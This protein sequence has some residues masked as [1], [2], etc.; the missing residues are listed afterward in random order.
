[1]RFN[2]KL[3]KSRMNENLNQV[4]N[5]LDR[6]AKANS[7]V[8]ALN[9][10]D[11]KSEWVDKLNRDEI[12]SLITNSETQK[13]LIESICEKVNKRELKKV[14]KKPTQKKS[15]KE[16]KIEKKSKKSLKEAN[17]VE[18]EQE[19]EQ[20]DS[21]TDNL[22]KACIDFLN[23][24][25]YLTK[26]SDNYFEYEVTPD[27]RDYLNMRD[28]DYIL[29]NN[30]IN[31]KDDFINY[32][33]EAYDFCIDYYSEFEDELFK[34]LDQNDIVYDR[35]DVNDILQEH[36]AIYP[37][38]DFYFRQEF[39][40]HIFVDT[41]DANYDFSLNPT[42]M[43]MT[44]DLED[45]DMNKASLVWLVQQQGYTKED[46]KNLLENGNSESKFLKS[47]Y[48]E[49][50]NNVGNNTTIA[51]LCKTTLGE[52]L[53]W[54]ANPTDITINK[55]TSIGLYDIFSGS[56][57]ILD[58]QL[59]KPLV[60]PAQ[61]IGEFWFDVKPKN[62]GGYSV[63]DVYGL[64]DEAYAADITLGNVSVQENL[65]EAHYNDETGEVEPD[66]FYGIPDVEFIWHGEWSDP[67]IAYQGKLYNY[68]DLE[69]SLY[70]LFEEDIENGDVV[71]D[72]SGYEPGPWNDA[73][74][75]AKDDKFA[76][77]VKDN[78]SL[79]YDEI[80][81]LEPTDTYEENLKESKSL[82]ESDYYNYLDKDYADFLE[83]DVNVYD[84]KALVEQETNGEYTTHYSHEYAIIVCTNGKGCVVDYEAVGQDFDSVDSEIEFGI[85]ENKDNEYTDENG[86]KHKTIS[87]IATH[88]ITTTPKEV[89][90]KAPKKTMKVRE[91]F[92]KYKYNDRC[93]DNFQELAEYVE[94]N[95]GVQESC[96]SKKKSK[97][98]KEGYIGQTLQDFLDDCIDYYMIDKIYIYGDTDIVYEGS[99][100]E[101]PDDMLN[102]E[103]LECEMYSNNRDIVVINVDSSEEYGVTTYYSTVED[104]VGDCNNDTVVVWDI[105]TDKEVFR[106]YR[107]EIPDDV[108]DM[109]FCSY[110][111]PSE[112]S[113]N[114]NDYEPEDNDFDDKDDDFDE[115]LKQFKTKKYNFRES[116]RL[117]K[118]KL[119]TEKKKSIK[120]ALDNEAYNKLANSNVDYD[121][122]DY[123]GDEFFIFGSWDDVM[124]AQKILAP[125]YEPTDDMDTTKIDELLN[126]NWGFR[127]EYD[128]CYHCGKIVNTQPYGRPDFVITEYE[129]LCN[130]CAKESEEYLQSLINNPKKANTV[131]EPDELEDLG[132]TR[133]DNNYE[134]G[135][136][137]RVDDPTEILDELLQKYPEGE[138]I[139]N[140]TSYGNPFATYF[141]VWGANMEEN[142]D[143]GTNENLNEATRKQIKQEE[144]DLRKQGVGWVNGEYHKGTPEQ[145][146]RMKELSC[147]EMLDSIICYG[148]K[149]TNGEDVVAY[150]ENNYRNY[151][152]DYIK[153]LGRERVV[154]LAQE[155][156]EDIKEIIKDVGTDSEGV[157]YN[158]IKY[159]D[160]NLKEDTVKQGGKWVNKGNTGETHGTFKTKKEADKQ[161]KAMFVNK[162]PNAKWGK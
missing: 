48:D 129:L 13:Q 12:I 91:F 160:E 119:L 162:K 139:F 102:A 32:L 108:L 150:E 157:M 22:E 47:V 18:V 15:L 96:Q 21:L 79:V 74:Q 23:S 44:I 110:D 81:L 133:L 55:A 137:D 138:F 83:S 33:D 103:F 25:N 34:Y 116:F 114:L 31:S 4:S 143:E 64:T 117:D 113:V 7:I 115:S 106:G 152:E 75:R 50:I 111:T 107:D 90:E 78:A 72:A 56:G 97:K 54:N 144:D 60:I 161:R 87:L 98:L 121:Y 61:Y 28:L 37:D 134:N 45:E 135:W 112:L 122:G 20:E 120:E 29:K 132:F 62:Y 126:G 3:L 156:L 123:E 19:V 104:F 101:I 49:V 67:E 89:M 40:C 51:I 9:F 27:Y 88:R 10:F 77:W 136:Y 128:T 85:V 154:E 73:E 140:I 70:E 95:N 58:I 39:R 155:Q 6:E 53:D 100:D 80:E 148:P 65:K 24:Q 5:P 131:Y 1:M 76:E 147:C 57:S 127:D 94:K 124:E 52:V 93:A 125:D 82:K 146:K 59:E 11:E 141:E 42:D 36:L 153:D 118:S 66:L 14:E 30:K 86:T 109:I 38:Y 8:E 145:E 99:I 46:L 69:N 149:F 130:D 105:A 142:E 16:N 2:E 68:Y 43:N 26:T 151:L 159:V 17:E 35:E 63:D 158:S 92:S 71:I 41:G 84:V